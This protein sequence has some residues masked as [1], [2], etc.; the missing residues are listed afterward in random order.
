MVAIDDLIRKLEQS[1]SIINE[2]KYE[3]VL[4]TWQDQV[5]KIKRAASERPESGKK[6]E[7]YRKQKSIEI[8]NQ[9]NDA[10]TSSKNEEAAL[11]FSLA[12]LL[13]DSNFVFYSNRSAAFANLGK[14]KEA[15]EDAV[16]ILQLNP[17]W[18]K[19]YS[20]MGVACFFLK[21]Y[22]ESLDAYKKGIAMEPNNEVMKSGLLQVQAKVS[23][24]DL[25]EKGENA[26][27]KGKFNEALANFDQ[28]VA[29]DPHECAFVA[30]RSDTFA[31][32][33]MF[34]KALQDI[35]QCITMKQ[36]WAKGYSRR[37]EIL[38]KLERYDDAAASYAIASQLD[39]SNPKWKTEMNNAI[40][41]GVR[42]RYRKGM[43][44]SEKKP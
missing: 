43:D 4:S 37:A 25:N 10:L 34:E 12:I 14:Y 31:R 13:D 20:R 33:G 8:K 22:D 27:A 9:G 35:D 29:L 26:V 44:K 41:E 7:E 18:P 21:K 17:S 2:L 36:D 39:P 40:Q 28:A 11:L 5:T 23:A 6:W 32:L 3:D 16:K 1:L 38:Y 15:Y 24:M 42:A 19:G 30:N